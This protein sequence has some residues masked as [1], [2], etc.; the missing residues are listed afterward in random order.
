MNS[1]EQQEILSLLVKV[2]ELEIDNMEMQSSCL[3]R[4]FEI[5]RKNMVLVKYQQHLSLCDEII[6]QQKSLLDEYMVTSP[7][8]LDELY[9]LYGQEDDMRPESVA[10]SL[11]DP[12]ILNKVSMASLALALFFSFWA[13]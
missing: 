8:E 4:N 1:S 12:F 3:L 5:R 11:P 7:K 9:E 10:T 2:H 13:P 6:Q